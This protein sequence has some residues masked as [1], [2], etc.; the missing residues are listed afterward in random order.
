MLLRLFVVIGDARAER[1]LQVLPEH[2]GILPMPRSARLDAP[3]AL[4]H[5]IGPGIEK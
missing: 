2:A 1:A 5:V 3:G 4:H